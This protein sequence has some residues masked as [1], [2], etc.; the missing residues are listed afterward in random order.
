[1]SDYSVEPEPYQGTIVV[2]GQ[3][4]TGQYVRV[5]LKDVPDLCAAMMQVSAQR[6]EAPRPGRV[7][8]DLSQPQDPKQGSTQT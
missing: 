3:S 6:H 7:P 5:Q 8:D 2:R 4:G 1:M